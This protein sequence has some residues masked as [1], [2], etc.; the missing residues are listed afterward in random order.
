MQDSNDEANDNLP[1]DD[2]I[3]FDDFD[4]NPTEIHYPKASSSDDE[5]MDL[6]NHNSLSAYNRNDRSF[7]G[8]GGSSDEYER[9][10]LGQKVN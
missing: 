9:S 6:T 8:E 7:K 1:G 3:E 2:E 10:V 5:M 4:F